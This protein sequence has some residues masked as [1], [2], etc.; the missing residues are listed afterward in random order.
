MEE[1]PPVEQ[2]PPEIP[3]AS[4]SQR[5]AAY[6]H[7]YA[8]R[9]NDTV[10]DIAKL[11]SQQG[12]RGVVWRQTWGQVEVAPGIYDFSSFDAALAAMA[13]SARPDCQLWL[14][15]EYKSFA[16]SP[17]KN[18]CP[19]YLRAN[20]SAPNADGSGASTCFMWEPVV[21]Q[22]YVAMMRAAAERYDANPRVEGLIL[23]E[24]ALGFNGAYAQEPGAGG[25]YS[26]EAWRDALI[27][28]VG[29]CGQAFTRS[30]CLSFLN[31]LRGGQ[32][33]LYDV[34]T[35][36]AAIPDNRGCMSGP[37][38]LPDE[39]TLYA[40]QSSVYEVITRHSGCRSNSAQNNSYAVEGCDLA[41][42]F[43][44]AVSGRFGDFP[45][46]APRA[47][48]LCVNS[49]L[50]WNHRVFQSPTG[51]NWSSALAVI[52]AN[53]YGQGWLEQCEGGGPAP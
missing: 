52:Q 9:Y 30:R 41:C 11:C 6:G 16:S 20:Y 29:Q 32:H 44:F 42:I 4:V 33:Y 37:D 23:Q 3:P 49:Y 17:V 24:S 19:E 48:G 39:K 45:Q 27:E 53:P 34:S 47:G 14:F 1:P 46:D 38:L 22:A 10:V 21:V 28:L 25:T 35:A 40:T 13:G 7:Y 43:R 2:P 26:A 5:K 15:I 31:F 51:L 36:I 18:P 12:V 8:T 50:F